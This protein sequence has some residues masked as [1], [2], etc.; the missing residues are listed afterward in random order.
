[1]A[2]LTIHRLDGDPADLLERKRTIFDPPVN[3]LAG[4]HGALYSFTAKT[5]TGLVV[6][7]VWRSQQDAARFTQLA[8]IQ[9][10]QRESGLP[11]PSSFERFDDADVIVYTRAGGAV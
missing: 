2:Y 6:V 1:M 3:E 9:D 8:E 4:E 11:M 10:A 5:D 7:N